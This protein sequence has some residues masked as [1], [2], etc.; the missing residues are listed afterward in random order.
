[1][2]EFMVSLY[3]YESEPQ[4][5]TNSGDKENDEIN[6]IIEH[7]DEEGE[8]S[9]EVKSKMK[10]KKPPIILQTSSETSDNKIKSLISYCIPHLN[11]QKMKELYKKNSTDS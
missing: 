1:M 10:R 7:E 9:K 8:H 4:E 2:K 6:F 5:I 3:S 11:H